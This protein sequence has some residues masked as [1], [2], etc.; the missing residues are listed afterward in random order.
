MNRVVLFCDDFYYSN[1]FHSILTGKNISVHTCRGVDEINRLPDNQEVLLYIV[2]IESLQFGAEVRKRISGMKNVIHVFDV[3]NTEPGTIF[4][5]YISKYM[6]PQTT[7]SALVR[8]IQSGYTN[9]IS[10]TD[11]DIRLVHLLSKGCNMHQIAGLLGAPV[12]SLYARKHTIMKKMGFDN[13]K[14]KSV[15]F[16]DAWISWRYGADDKYEPLWMSSQGRRKL[17]IADF[18]VTEYHSKPFI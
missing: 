5:G 6:A 12:K 1:G 2:A 11:G 9:N 8:H 10:L 4:R 15:F 7:F 3:H 18:L 13:A 14:A 16:C 17:S